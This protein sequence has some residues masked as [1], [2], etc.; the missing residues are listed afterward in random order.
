MH[1]MTAQDIIRV[2]NR[3]YLSNH[4]YLTNNLYLFGWESDYAACTKAG[5]WYEVEVKISRADFFNDFKKQKKHEILSGKRPGLRPNYFTYAV[6]EGLIQPEEI[7]EYAGLIFISEK[8]AHYYSSGKPTPRI[9]GVKIADESLQLVEKFY[10]NYKNLLYVRD[11]FQA[12]TGELRGEIAWLK[13]EFK[14]A[15]GYDIKEIL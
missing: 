9:H 11:N 8:G 13:K 3:C 15:T 10:Y 2:L 4:R 1:R 12:V 14:A 6:P 5:Y 7:P